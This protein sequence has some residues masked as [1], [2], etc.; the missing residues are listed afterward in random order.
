MDTRIKRFIKQL[1]KA[2][3]LASDLGLT[4]GNGSDVAAMLGSIVT[5]I[6]SQ[7]NYAMNTDY[8][9]S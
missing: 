8:D 9:R 3:D 2:Q 1:E 4:L 5:E 6:E 7:G